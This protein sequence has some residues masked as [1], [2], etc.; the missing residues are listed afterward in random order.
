MM[1]KKMETMEEYLEMA[2][3]D[4]PADWVMLFIQILKTDKSPCVKHEAAFNIGQLF[5]KSN[6]ED[7]EKIK[8]YV[9]HKF[10]EVVENDESLVVR[11]EAIE[12]IGDAGLNTLEVRNL[13]DK[14]VQHENYDIANTAQISYWQITGKEI[15]T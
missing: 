7:L 4:Q 12:S 8:D 1:A 14:Y 5:S 3:N 11:H 2:F 15:G 6:D 9:A 10:C 13:L